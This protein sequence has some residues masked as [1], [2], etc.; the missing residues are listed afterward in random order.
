MRPVI[1]TSTILLTFFI[2]GC[3]WFDDD[4]DTTGGAG[5]V[6]P[7]V[8]STAATVETAAASGEIEYTDNYHHWNPRSWKGRGSS[9]VLCPGAPKYDSCEI[10]GRSLRLHGNRDYGRWVWT[11]YNKKGLKGNIICRDGD[12][13]VG[14]R[15]SSTGSIQYGD[16]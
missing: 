5:T 10:E 2:S 14:Y 6:Q 11:D 15:T 8:Q 3:D 1:L 9:L 12:K 4:D 7:A 13:V 16:C